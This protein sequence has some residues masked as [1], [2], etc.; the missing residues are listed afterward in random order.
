[1]SLAQRRIIANGVLAC[2]TLVAALLRFFPPGSYAI[3]PKCPVYVCFH[4]LCP[5]CGATR[6][7]AALLGGRIHEAFHW[8]PLA[9][10]CMPFL[11]LFLGKYYVRAVRAQEFVFP[12]VPQASLTV[13]LVGM[14]AFTIVRNLHFF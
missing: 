2:G 12:D 9:I 14:A 7:M 6:A 8:N 11:L 10:V 1:M 4:I 13:C 5:G 3:Y